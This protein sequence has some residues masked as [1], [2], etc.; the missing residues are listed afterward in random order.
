MMRS[1]ATT[2]RTSVL[3]HLRTGVRVT[4]AEKTRQRALSQGMD[5]R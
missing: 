4:Q 2:K 3:V 1:Q 5:G